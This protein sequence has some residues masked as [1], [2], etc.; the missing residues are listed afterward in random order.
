MGQDP[1]E[2]PTPINPSDL[3]PQKPISF[4]HFQQKREREEG[5]K[6]REGKK[7]KRGRREGRSRATFVPIDSSRDS[8]LLKVINT[9]LA[10]FI[11][12][13]SRLNDEGEKGLKP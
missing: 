5:R 2:R 4:S 9:T 8:H 6:E 12:M 1:K 11:T 7:G 3:E 10:S 13:D